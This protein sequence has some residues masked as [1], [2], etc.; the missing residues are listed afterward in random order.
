MKCFNR[1]ERPCVAHAL[2][3]KEMR[4]MYFE[5]ASPLWLHVAPISFTRFK[6]VSRL[7][8]DIN[9]SSK[10]SLRFRVIHLTFLVTSGAR[11]GVRLSVLRYRPPFKTAVQH[12]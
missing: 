4:V 5:A 9:H 10:I 7:R 2:A 11:Q 1:C 6:S 12:G 3:K 8:L